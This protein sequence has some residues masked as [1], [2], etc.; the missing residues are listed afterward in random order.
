MTDSLVSRPRATSLTAG[1]RA[2]LRAILIADMRRQAALAA[3]HAATARQLRGQTDTDSVL[4]RELAV[5][6]AARAREAIDDIDDALDRM[7]T[8]TYGTCEACGIPI[9]FER[10]EAIPHARHCIACPGARGRFRR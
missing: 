8:G 6:A 4:E 7:A 2:R 9:P 5:A 3:E 1:A 10:L